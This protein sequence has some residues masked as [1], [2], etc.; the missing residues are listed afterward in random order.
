MITEQ[1]MIF[2]NKEE[3]EQLFLMNNLNLIPL[4]SIKINNIKIEEAK[5]LNI[6]NSEKLIYILE[7]YA[8]NEILRIDTDNFATIEM[9]FEFRYYVMFKE[10][11]KFETLMALRE[12]EVRKAIKDLIKNKLDFTV[13]YR[14]GNLEEENLFNE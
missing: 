3:L 8:S 5:R 10:E 7:D 11:E 14:I 13:E 12:N 2:K 4:K 1:K 9:E 6:E